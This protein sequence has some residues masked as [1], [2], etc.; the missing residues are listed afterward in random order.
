[1]RFLNAGVAEQ[2]MVGVAAGIA[3]TGYRPW[4]YSI[5]PF[6][7]YRCF[8]QIRNDVCLHKLPVRLVGNGGGYTYG[9]MGS[10]HH[11]L[12]ELGALKTLP[13][14]RLY[15]PCTNDHVP[16]AV[17]QIHALSSPSYL[18]LAISGFAASAPGPVA[19]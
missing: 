8:E 11:T 12:E 4:V 1:P 2:N 7:T 16:S 9:I 19:E 17:A 10:T 5:A 3:M 14:M 18:R 15:F 6:V 13:N